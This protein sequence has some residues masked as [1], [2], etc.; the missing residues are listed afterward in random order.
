MLDAIVGYAGGSAEDANYDRVSMG[1]TKHKEAIQVFYDPN[2]I[3][4]ADLLDIFWSHIDPT[5]PDGQ[6]VDK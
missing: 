6:F 2:I 5:D 1:R 3:S 4:Y